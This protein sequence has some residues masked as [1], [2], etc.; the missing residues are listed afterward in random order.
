[1][2]KIE[3]IRLA[4]VEGHHYDADGFRRGKLGAEPYHVHFTAD[5]KTLLTALDAANEQ[6]RELEDILRNFVDDEP[7]VK[8][9]HGFCQTHDCSDPCDN[10]EALRILEGEKI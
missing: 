2:S 9:H 1:M 4:A 7:C 5:I 8:D 6:V 10:A 3:R